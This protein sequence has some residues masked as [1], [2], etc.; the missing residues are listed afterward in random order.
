MSS[1]YI[2][3]QTA[4]TAEALEKKEAAYVK[5]YYGKPYTGERLKAELQERRNIE[6]PANFY[7]LLRR[8][9]TLGTPTLFTHGTLRSFLKYNILRDGSRNWIVAGISLIAF[10]MLAFRHVPGEWRLSVNY[11]AYGSGPK[12][13]GLGGLE[14]IVHM[15]LGRP[16]LR[17]N[18]YIDF[19]QKQD[20]KQE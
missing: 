10:T 13:D 14:K 19:N 15:D 2:S 18:R 3:K 11:N 16:P 4:K 17:S 7:A 20:Q 6:K 1:D 5:D 12:Y 9:R 8:Q